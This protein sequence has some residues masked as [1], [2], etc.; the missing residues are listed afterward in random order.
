[1]VAE[2]TGECRRKRLPLVDGEQ[3]TAGRIKQTLTLR[4]PC[5]WRLDFLRLPC[6]E[7]MRCEFRSRDWGGDGGQTMEAVKGYGAGVENRMM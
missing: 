5:G 3:W 1:M 4:G 2:E 6:K 7:N